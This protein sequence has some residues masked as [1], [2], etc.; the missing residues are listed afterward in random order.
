[1]A[2]ALALAVVL[3]SPAPAPASA[4]PRVPQG[5][6]GMMADGPLFDPGVNL[7]RQLDKMVASGVE[8]LRVVFSWSAAQPYP[9]AAA[10]PGSLAGQ[11]SDIVDGVPTDFSAT[12]RIVGLAAHRGLS[13][14]PVA[15]YAPSWDLETNPPRWDANPVDW[16][17][18]P[19]DNGPFTKYLAA[20]VERYG[21]QGS[22][23]KSNPQ[24]PRLPIRR[25]QVWNEPNLSYFWSSEPFADTYVTML[26]SAHDA[27]KAADPGAQVVLAGLANDSWNAL[28]AIY[29]VNGA[30]RLFDAVAIHPYTAQAAGV[31]TILRLVRGVM[32]RYGDRSKPLLVTELGWPSSLGRV[33]QTFG[34][35]T[36]PKGQ[37]QRLASVIP[38]LAAARRQLGITGFDVYTWLGDETPGSTAFN[39]SGLFAFR[40]ATDS[41]QVKPAYTAFRKAALAVEGCRLKAAIASRCRRTG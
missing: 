41:I 15:M 23:W 12:D 40:P 14:L 22:F 19:H 1:M 6:V 26:R 17:I 37:A 38:M 10:V 25:W 33:S 24:I 35:A 27:I 31:L 16:P 32:N 21:P 34:L 29:Q 2:W 11:F 30:Q 3:I 20:L 4:A 13:V 18:Q 36:T 7:P 5:F 8:S 9:T 28:D 39:Y